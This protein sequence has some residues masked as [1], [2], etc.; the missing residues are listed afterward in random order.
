[1]GKNNFLHSVSLIIAI[2]TMA[3]FGN[4]A[5]AQEGSDGDS[6]RIRSCSNATSNWSED[7]YSRVHN[8]MC[9]KHN[10]DDIIIETKFFNVNYRGDNGWNKNTYPS[11]VRVQTELFKD[12]RRVGS[13]YQELEINSDG[14][15]SQIRF[16]AM[17]E[18]KYT[19]K[20]KGTLINGKWPDNRASEVTLDGKMDNPLY[21]DP[22]H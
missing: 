17:L 2:V 20:M 4:S 12:A 21:I 15:I 9:I 22:R 6:P 8:S 14:L 18:G 7:K 10:E 3:T 1:M 11:V 16:P 19:A 5:Y 13:V